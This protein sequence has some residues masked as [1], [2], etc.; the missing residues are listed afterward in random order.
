MSINLNVNQFQLEFSDR[1]DLLLQE[2]G[3]SKLRQY[4][5]NDSF[6]GSKQASPVNQV[7][8][9]KGSTPAG[10]F[11]P[12]NRVDAETDRRWVFP[13]D[14]ELAQ[15]LDK[16]D[17]LRYSQDFKGPYAQNA[18]NDF[19]RWIDQLIID[20]AIGD[21][22][23]GE[24]GAGTETFDTTNQRIAAN[25]GASGN[26]GLTVDKLIALQEKFMSNNVDLE[27][28]TPTLVITEKQHSDLLRQTE[29]V[30]TEFR[31]QPVLDGK[32]RVTNFLGFNIVVKVQNANDLTAPALPLLSAGLRR[33]FAFVPS[34]MCLG[35]WQDFSVRVDERKDLSGIPWQIYACATAGATRL[36]Q[37][38]VIDVICAE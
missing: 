11:A 37:G 5:M 10:R 19:G 33:C 16:F 29:V 1:V 15:M 34:G 14:R 28:E 6:T 17:M 35:M 30:S 3:G 7:G 25:T 18:A 23:I 21:A 9:V 12:L 8:A 24:L 31:S 2:G 22:R 20:A 4:V 32:G 38:R 13:A 27:T 36:E 26:V